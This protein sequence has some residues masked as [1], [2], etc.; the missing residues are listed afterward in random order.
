MDKVSLKDIV[1]Q[2]LGNDSKDVDYDTKSEEI[3]IIEDEECI[4]TDPD[5]YKRRSDAALRRGDRES[6]INEINEA[7]KYSHNA[8]RYLISRLS[9]Q[10]DK[11]CSRL[12]DFYF[13][14]FSKIYESGE[15][16]KGKYN[17]R[18]MLFPIYWLLI[19]NCGKESFLFIINC[20]L[21][22]MVFI[23]AALFLGNRYLGILDNPSP[24]LI[25]GLFLIGIIPIVIAKFYI[26]LRGTYIYYRNF[27]SKKKW[28]LNLRPAMAVIGVIMLLGLSWM[29]FIID[30]VKPITTL[31][32]AL[33]TTYKELYENNSFY[34]NPEDSY[35]ADMT[36]PNDTVDQEAS[37]PAKPVEKPPVHE[38]QE[39][40]PVTSDTKKDNQ[41]QNSDQEIAD[42]S[43][44]L[45]DRGLSMLN[46]A[47]EY[48]DTSEFKRAKQ[49]LET[50][51]EL[52][53]A[54]AMLLTG[55]LY[56]YGYDYEG[57]YNKALYWYIKAGNMGIP[58]GYYYA[59]SLYCENEQY[60]DALPLLYEAADSN[61]PEAMHDIGY[62]YQNGYGLPQDYKAAMTWYL[63][64]A[65]QGYAPSMTNIG[66]LY[67]KGLGVTQDYETAFSWYMK[68]AQ[69]EDQKAMRNVSQMYKNGEGVEQNDEEAKKWVDKAD[70]IRWG[71]R[72]AGWK[73]FH[74]QLGY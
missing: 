12:P 9:I 7:L 18:A 19:K 40:V 56:K 4:I 53:N 51:A 68:A 52:G 66:A 5:L 30:G 65:D 50:A 31:T 1:E 33:N 71:E 64:A 34:N 74:A 20:L 49:T 29:T 44:T 60:D 8:R 61:I 48:G 37:E 72:D 13:D 39:T 45:Y 26:G 63:K 15:K 17:K 28:R 47:E 43:Q 10:L 6:A 21:Y 69:L 38:F 54:N 23:L 11:D 41:I 36:T 14:E 55:A 25:C 59:G 46:T 35:N 67:D 57:D 16:Y 70:E 24:L 62:S 27:T 2:H 58:M 22:A 3:E 73:W 32:K 42:D